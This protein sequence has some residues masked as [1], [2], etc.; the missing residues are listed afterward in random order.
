LRPL[1]I[2]AVYL[3]NLCVLCSSVVFIYLIMAKQEGPIFFTGN[4]GKLNFY[5]DKDGYQVRS[6]GGV[7]AERINSDPKFG[8]T[9][10]NM[11][12][13]GA[14]SSTCKLICDSFFSLKSRTMMTEVNTRM[15]KVLVE[16]K[17]EDKVNMRGERAMVEGDW[18]R[19]IDF[20]LNTN[21]PLTRILR[22]PYEIS[23]SGEMLRFSLPQFKAMQMLRFPPNATHFRFHLHR[24]DFQLDDDENLS[25]QQET[26]LIPLEAP[27]LDLQLEVPMGSDGYRYSLCLL[28]IEFF[29]VNLGK[30]FPLAKGKSNPCKIVGWIKQME[31]TT[32]WTEGKTV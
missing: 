15:Q 9:L 27:A 20:D 2:L 14:A 17:M 22:W 28:G 11:A 6:K 4:I 23:Q 30:A 25:T 7:T 12:E 24:L 8:R 32:T 29:Q 18:N 13:F 3:L 21:A 16:M 5:K 19:L 1:A 10:E 31:E 26:P